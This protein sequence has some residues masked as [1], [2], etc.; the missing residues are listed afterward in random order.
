MKNLL[1][2]LLTVTLMSCSTAQARMLEADY[3]L[4]HCM[5]RVEVVLQD[6]TRV[7]C[8]TDEYAIEY[9]W[10]HKWAEA[11]GQSLHYA[12]MTGKKPGIVLIMKPGDEKYL[13][14]LK[15]IAFNA[16]IKVWTVWR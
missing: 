13:E 9:D 6:S 11:V 5:G 12:R 15:P 4:E 7:D 3:V 16:G 8:L 14:R 10:A 2:F 1:L